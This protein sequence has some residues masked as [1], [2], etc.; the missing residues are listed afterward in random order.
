MNLQPV[1]KPLPRLSR[2]QTREILRISQRCVSAILIALATF[3]PATALGGY[4]A[5]RSFATVAVFSHA[6]R[7]GRPPISSRRTDPPD[8]R[9][10]PFAEGRVVD[11]LYEKLMRESARVLNVHE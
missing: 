4:F 10:D 3:R 1:G 8:A 6:M 11:Q 2:Q 9:P 7:P 5:T